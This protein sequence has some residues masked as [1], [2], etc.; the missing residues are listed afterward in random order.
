MSLFVSRVDLTH[1]YI[2]FAVLTQTIHGRA[3]IRRHRTTYRDRQK[4]CRV[5][6]EA[7]RFYRSTILARCRLYA[8][9]VKVKMINGSLGVMK[10][11]NT[12]QHLARLRIIYTADDRP[13]GM[14][15]NQ[16]T[17]CTIA[18]RPPSGLEIK[19]SFLIFLAATPFQSRF[20]FSRVSLSSY[21]RNLCI[22]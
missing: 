6:G 22:K 16:L 15:I 19:F 21:G 13:S 3:D 2:C 10:T 5:D 18:P 8:P 14:S 11:S 12:I 9:H 4:E 17:K 20:M 7:D 1:N